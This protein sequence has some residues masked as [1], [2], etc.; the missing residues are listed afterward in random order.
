MKVIIVPSLAEPVGNVW[1]NLQAKYTKKGNF[2]ISSPLSSTPLPVYEWVI[3]N[4]KFFKNWHKVKFVLMDE[5]LEDNRS[6]FKYVPLDDPASYEGFARKNLLEPLAKKVAV[7]QGVIKPELSK[8]KKFETPIDLLILAIGVKGSYANVMPG[9]AVQTGWHIAH[10]IAEFRQIH[11]QQGSK[12]YEGANFREF[13]MSL[14]PQ[15]GLIAEN[16][17]VIISGEKKRELAKK[18]LAQKNFNPNFPLSIIYHP[19]AREKTTVF[20]TEDVGVK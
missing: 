12:S 7:S 2:Y 19:L 14:G 11:T 1:K 4:C 15:Q 3:A 17:V 9:T 20:L 6:P 5:M 16:I 8:I 18:F 10:L 13:G